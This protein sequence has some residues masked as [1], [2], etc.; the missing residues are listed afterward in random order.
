MPFGNFG[1]CWAM[2]CLNSAY[3]TYI[4]FSLIPTF[5]FPNIAMIFSIIFGSGCVTCAR[6]GITAVNRTSIRKKLNLKV[7]GICACEPSRCLPPALHNMCAVPGRAAPQAEPCDDLIVHFFCPLCAVCQEYR[8]LKA[9]HGR[10]TGGNH[11][12]RL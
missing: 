10:S 12:N 4:T 9:T 5:T 1:A 11:F 3:I 8:E 7:R 6:F 2:T